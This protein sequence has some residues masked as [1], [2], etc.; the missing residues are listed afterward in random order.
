[1]STA[2]RHLA[3]ALAASLA[4]SALAGC[5]DESPP[6]DPPS[7]A[8]PPAEERLH[9]EW[10]E[11]VEVPPQLR[12][13]VDTAR[14]WTYAY[15]L[16]VTEPSTI[17]EYLTRHSSE[18]L[19]DTIRANSGAPWTTGAS[20]TVLV[21]VDTDDEVVILGICEDGRD[22]SIIDETGQRVPGTKGSISSARMQLLPT[23][24]G[25]W[26]VD[27]QGP[28]ADLDLRTRCDE[29]ATDPPPTNPAE[30]G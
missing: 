5:T 28:A 16:W 30:V 18:E 8:I 27:Y 7:A 10:H 13:P 3:C 22:R 11:D 23:A 12:V 14:D 15:D 17:P 1:M 26:L 4:V 19:L 2:T 25:G 6:P 20:R 29:L 24:N 9:S 21:E